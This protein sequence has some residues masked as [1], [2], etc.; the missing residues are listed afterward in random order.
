MIYDLQELIE[1]VHNVI[2]AL[3][4]FLGLIGFIVVFLGFFLILVM[5]SSA[6]KESLSELKVMRA[7]G[8][9]FRDIQKIYII[10]SVSVVFS[11][12]IIGIVNNNIN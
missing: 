12:G 4:G 7:I 8:L 5:F 9:C 2:T 1:G 3:K 11:A 10:E 6:I